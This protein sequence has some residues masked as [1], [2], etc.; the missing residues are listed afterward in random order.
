VTSAFLLV[1]C[2]VLVTAVSARDEVVKEL[3]TSGASDFYVFNREPLLPNALAKL[4]IGSIEPM[5]W[6]K[7]Q[8]DLMK[9]GMTGRLDEISEFLTPQSGWWTGR[10]HGWEE[11]PYW[12][13]GFGDLGYVLGDRDIQIRARKWLD[14]AIASQQDD[15]YFGSP[16]NKA[17][18]D[19]WPE[20][21]R[22]GKSRFARWNGSN[23]GRHCA[24]ES[25]S[26]PESESQ[27]HRSS[28]VESAFVAA[29]RLVSAR[30]AGGIVLIL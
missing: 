11:M 27:G 3:P 24:A 25:S 23:T 26:C 9:D 12:L 4:P 10:G 2:L 13:K 8:L 28:K 14:A 7:G 22:K 18:K 17:K 30:R 29:A 1:L 6:L 15:G 16:E 20:C 19:L 5:G 21:Q